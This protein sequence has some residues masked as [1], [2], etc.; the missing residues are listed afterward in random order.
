MHKEKILK[1]GRIQ[2]REGEKMTLNQLVYFQTVARYQHF[3]R[4][5]EELNIS[6]PSLSRSVATLEEELRI[7]LFERQGRNVRLTKYGRVFLE[8]TE[9]ILKDVAVARTQMQQLSGN[10]GHVDI[11]YV[12]PLAAH[13]IPHM[14]RRF[15]KK[16]KNKNVTFS[17]HQLHTAPLIEGLK[18]EKYDIIF[19]SYVENEPLVQFIPIIHQD[20]VII[21][22]WDHPLARR[23]KATLQDLAEYPIIGYD[24]TSGLGKYTRRLYAIHGLAPDIICESPDENAISALVEEA[25][26]I[27]LVT[28]VEE[29]HERNVHIL[30]VED[31]NLV[32]TVYMAY[33]KDR[34]MIPAVKN[35]IH[36]IHKEGTKL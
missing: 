34:Y 13:Y 12:F 5:A 32:H 21:T 23:G 30:K 33:L 26:G 8:H 10:E 25:F 29:I 28:D 1:S 9:K 20:M 4:A 36:F 17:F 15:L 6:Q 22:P 19:G 24:R 35:F 18:S 31:E 2:I 7:V 3:H 14:V 27:A 11:A 16:E